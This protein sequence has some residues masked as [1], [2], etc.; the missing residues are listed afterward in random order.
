MKP[1]QAHYSEAEF[2]LA[3]WYSYP[4]TLVNAAERFREKWGRKP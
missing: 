4:K 2:I 3:H 1:T